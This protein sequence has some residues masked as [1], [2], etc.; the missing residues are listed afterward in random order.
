MS[1][2]N[3]TFKYFLNCW[4]NFHNT[5]RNTLFSQNIFLTFT[6]IFVFNWFIRWEFSWILLLFFFFG[7]HS[8]CG[9]KWFQISTTLF[10]WLLSIWK[11]SLEIPRTI[12]RTIKTLKKILW[13]V[14]T[15]SCINYGVLNNIEKYELI[16]FYYWGGE[17][18]LLSSLHSFTRS[19]N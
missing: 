9:L 12:L 6:R 1:I 4:F 10:S 16:Y 5:F 18:F 3:T 14:E 7:G 13:T 11:A 15:L 17:I 19:N 8:I 2:I